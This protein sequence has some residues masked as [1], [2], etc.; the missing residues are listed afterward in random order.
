[1]KLSRALRAKLIPSFQILGNECYHYT[2]GDKYEP[3]GYKNIHARAI[4]TCSTPRLKMITEPIPSID[5]FDTIINSKTHSIFN[6]MNGG[7]TNLPT[8]PENEQPELHLLRENSGAIVENSP[9]D[10]TPKNSWR[11]VSNPLEKK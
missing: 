2:I 6:E 8:S 7:P 4:E 9:I 10:G 1:M 5:T 11:L 3:A